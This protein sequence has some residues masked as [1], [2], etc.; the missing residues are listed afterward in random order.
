MPKRKLSLSDAVAWDGIIM[1]IV[2]RLKIIR[3]TKFKAKQ[4]PKTPEKQK[5]DP[6]G[7]KAW[8]LE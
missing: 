4:I 7:F 3:L 6:N 5:L 8:G 2:G 1:T